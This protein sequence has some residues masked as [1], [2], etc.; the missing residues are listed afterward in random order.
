[1]NDENLLDIS[2]RKE[3]KKFSSK[4][5]I[6]SVKTRRNNKSIKE[7]FTE[8]LSSDTKDSKSLEKLKKYGKDKS[9]QMLMVISLFELVIEKGNKS[10]DAW[11]RIMEIIG[12]TNNNED[13]KSF[14]NLIE[15]IKNV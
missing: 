6:N 3:H 15:A 13:D 11:D 7:M 12:E 2:K 4:G 14:N 9:N 8:L 1:M 10:V 5:G